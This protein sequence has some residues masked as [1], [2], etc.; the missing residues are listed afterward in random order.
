[1]LKAIRII[2]L[3]VLLLFLCLCKAVWINT[4]KDNDSS[5]ATSVGQLMLTTADVTGWQQ[6]GQP[7]AIFSAATLNQALDGGDIPYIQNGGLIAVGIQEMTGSG[8]KQ[9]E[10][11]CIDYGA[12]ATAFSYFQTWTVQLTVPKKIPN[13]NDSLAVFESTGGGTAK[14]YAHFKKF[15][16]EFRLSGFQDES[17]ALETASLFLDIYASRIY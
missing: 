9:V 5:V 4:S 12:E 15:Y 6:A 2:L 1:M 3:G 7:F 10:L 16:I 8:G 17:D 14:V 13:Y 11:F